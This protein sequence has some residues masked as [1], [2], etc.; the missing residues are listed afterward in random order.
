MEIMRTISRD[1]FYQPNLSS[2]VEAFRVDAKTAEHNM[3]PSQYSSLAGLLMMAEKTPL[4]ASKVRESAVE[5]ET[6]TSS[7]NTSLSASDSNPRSTPGPSTH[8]QTK[9]RLSKGNRRLSIRG[10]D[11]AQA[12]I[13]PPVRDHVPISGSTAKMLDDLAVCE[14]TSREGSQY[15]KLISIIEHNGSEPLS[16]NLNEF[17]NAISRQDLWVRAFRLACSRGHAQVLQYLLQFFFPPVRDPQAGLPA[18]RVFVKN[19]NMLHTLAQGGLLRGLTVEPDSEIYGTMVSYFGQQRFLSA[20]DDWGRT[21]LQ[22][23]LIAGDATMSRMLIDLM[24]GSDVK[25]AI[26]VTD[27]HGWTLLHYACKHNLLDHAAHLIEKGAN[28]HART[29]SYELPLHVACDNGHHE[30][31][32]LV[33]LLLR[34]DDEHAYAQRSDGK[35]PLHLAALHNNLATVQYLFYAI[36]DR[37]PHCIHLQ[38]DLCRTPLMLAKDAQVMEEF[39]PWHDNTCKRVPAVCG[40]YKAFVWKWRYDSS[41]S[42]EAWSDPLPVSVYRLLHGKNEGSLCALESQKQHLTWIHVPAN[43]KEWCDHLLTR[44]YLENDDN[45]DHD[46]DGLIAARRAFGQQHIGP[47]KQD[48]FLR[49][50]VQ[51]VHPRIPSSGKK[52]HNPAHKGRRVDTPQ[53]RVLFIAAPYIHFDTESN[54][55][56]MQKTLGL[57]RRY[58]AQAERKMP[59][60]E[61]LYA[62][63]RDDPGFHPRRTLDQYVYH[64]MDTADRDSDQVIQ[65]FQRAYMLGMPGVDEFSG[66]TYREIISETSL[67]SARP[68]PRSSRSL[69]APRKS[70]VTTL[71]VDQLWIWILGERLVITCAP[72]R[73]SKPEDD[74]YDVF[75]R[76]KAHLSSAVEPPKSAGDLAMLA[77]T[78]CF[79]TFDRHARTA[80]RLQ[81]MNMFEQS[82]GRI[83]ATEST[84]LKTFSEA[85]RTLNR[86]AFLERPGDSPVAENPEF[87]KFV[88]TLNDLTTET[89]LLSELK[90]IRD[91]LH[92]MNTILTDQQ[93]VS[94]RLLEVQAMLACNKSTTLFKPSTLAPTAS[95][96][97][98]DIFEPLN[99][100]IGQGLQDIERLDA[101]ATRLSES[102]SELLQ[103]KQAHSNAFELEFSRNLSLET[104]KLSRDA[105]KQGRAV[106]VF[107]IVTIVF[108]PLSF[109]AAFFTMQLSNL[110]DPMSLSY[111]S[112][113]I[114]GFG[115]AVAIP[116]VVLAFSVSSW[117]PRAWRFFRQRWNPLGQGLPDSQRD[118]DLEAAFSTGTFPTFRSSQAVGERPSAPARYLMSTS[119]SEFVRPRRRKIR[120]GGDLD[121]ILDR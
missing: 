24:S 87:R 105:A 2:I 85:Y 115:F 54:V 55:R 38:D 78:E 120:I 77:M 42:D 108:S 62:E 58:S 70:D 119:L 65:R 66:D 13:L 89:D 83:A 74:P 22:W 111:V 100:T 81:V 71:M 21:P 101:Q 121:K 79:G 90:D 59:R 36:G 7:S 107:T 44:W 26:K 94:R 33:K 19:M 27:N 37:Q 32:D 10:L 30:N 51:Y 80:Q 47:G 98:E 45:W 117:W 64:N 6:V 114:F 116:C 60:D 76:M 69:K 39:A 49:P 14:E 53:K 88:R 73:W 11:L 67:P 18:L 84:L 113:Y 72:Q 110:P 103:L 8:S 23:A 43:N 50:G 97:Q 91:E 68:L 17:S 52:Q 1:T 20:I 95:E 28:V 9:L 112:K 31:T 56:R 48:R 5:A 96:R 86:K 4:S 93:K 46:V 57:S 3:E 82:I 16:N 75:D 61:D 25:N 109:V 106:L 29:K 102:L 12:R 63:Y 40:D 34:F 41:A 104:T 118:S 99:A 35:T 92:I 15:T